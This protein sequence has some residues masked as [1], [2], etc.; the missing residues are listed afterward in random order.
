MIPS[1]GYAT[2]PGDCIYHKRHT[3]KSRGQIQACGGGI[4]IFIAGKRVACKDGD[5]SVKM[6]NLS[7]VGLAER[8]TS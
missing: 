8:L 7:V 3:G 4:G 2:G 5:R 1:Y 6:F